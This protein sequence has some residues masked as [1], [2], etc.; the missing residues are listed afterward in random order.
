MEWL[1]PIGGGTMEIM[2]S[3]QSAFKELIVSDLGNSL[4]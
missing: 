1:K 3:I 2:E 4:P